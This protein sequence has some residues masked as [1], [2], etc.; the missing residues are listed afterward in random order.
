MGGGANTLLSGFI[1]GGFFICEPK[2]FD[3]I[4]EGDSTIFEQSPLKNL[5]LDG[6]LY[7]YCHN[8]FWKCM[9][10]LKD[11]SDLTKMWL[12]GNA[13]W[14]VWNHLNQGR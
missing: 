10:T 8:G 13:P 12:S 4:T 9:D 3:Y 5:A 1:N 11:K 6:E 14:K 2:I 7:T